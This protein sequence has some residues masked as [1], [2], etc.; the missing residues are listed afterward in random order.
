MVTYSLREFQDHLDPITTS[1]RSTMPPSVTSSP[2]ELY[3]IK[4]DRDRT[5]KCLQTC[6]EVLCCI[7]AAQLQL[8]SERA[9]TQSSSGSSTGLS[10]A[11][12]ITTAAL[13]ECG[14]KLNQTLSRLYIH[15]EKM[16]M[17]LPLSSSPTEKNLTIR[18]HDASSEKSLIL[19]DVSVGKDGRQTI[20]CLA[21]DVLEVKQATV[22][23]R[24]V[25]FIGSVWDAKPQEMLND[26]GL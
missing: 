4:H 15:M 2:A 25:Q 9:T 21:G 20:V 10:E 18:N 24:A 11:H 7:D 13:Q 8:L 22:G 1:I 14:H 16:D 26:R 23:D 19:G 3:T 17:E 6:A 5:E 12:L